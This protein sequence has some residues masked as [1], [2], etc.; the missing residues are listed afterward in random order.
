M[1]GV[2][3][4][5]W[6]LKPTAMLNALLIRYF[7]KSTSVIH[8]IQVIA[9]KTLDWGILFDDPVHVDD[10]LNGR[11]PSSWQSLYYANQNC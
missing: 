11:N 3:A 7:I 8:K 2:T 5:A 1:A 6:R 4:G 9:D 10:Y